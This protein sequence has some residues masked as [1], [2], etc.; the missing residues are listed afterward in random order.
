MKNNLSILLLPLLLLIGCDSK[1]SS[2]GTDSAQ[3]TPATAV[4]EMQPAK[5][6]TT[7]ATSSE[8]KEEAVAKVEESVAKVSL[9]GEDI[10]NRSCV[11]CHKSGVANAP[12]LGDIA[13]WSPRIAKGTDALYKSAISGVPGTAMMAKGT[14]G[15]CSDAELKATVDYMISKS[16]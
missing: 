5:T 10:Y 11:N 8:P 9:S 1:Q 6:E 7:Q 14:C 12:K 15:A 13:A 3:P 4:V 16:K 2:P